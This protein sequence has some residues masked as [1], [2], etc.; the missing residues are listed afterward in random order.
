[1][2]AAQLQKHTVGCKYTLHLSAHSLHN[3]GSVLR[4][5]H[6]IDCSLIDDRTATSA[7]QSQV[8]RVK[9]GKVEP[10]EARVKELQCWKR[11]IAAE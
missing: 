6:R 7:A 9:S 4:T 5:Q 1:M 8:A 3:C 10:W 2:A 11:V